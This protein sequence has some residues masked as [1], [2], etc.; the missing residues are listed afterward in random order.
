MLTQKNSNSHVISSIDIAEIAMIINTTRLQKSKLALNG[1]HNKLIGFSNYDTHAVLIEWNPL[2]QSRVHKAHF[3]PHRSRLTPIVK[4]EWKYE[5]KRVALRVAGMRART[6]PSSLTS[7][8]PQCRTWPTCSATHSAR[9]SCSRR[10]VTATS[11]DTTITTTATCTATA[12]W[13]PTSSTRTW[14]TCGASGCPPRR[15]PLLRK[16]SELKMS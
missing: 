1:F 3:S 4:S 2:L 13:P 16:V 8:W 11:S 6:R 7:C 12:W 9:S 14:R 5:S 15:S 10:L